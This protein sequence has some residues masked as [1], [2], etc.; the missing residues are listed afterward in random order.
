[1]SNK[2]SDM[3][4]SARIRENQRR[5]R[6]KRRELIEDLQQRVRDYELK[7]VE[8]T[9]DMQRAA[10]RVAQENLGLRSMLAQRGVTQEEVQSFLR[11]F[12]GNDAPVQTQRIALTKVATIQCVTPKA[13]S[14]PGA[15][16][17]HPLDSAQQ[18]DEPVSR[19]QCCPGNAREHNNA[20]QVIQEMEMDGLRLSKCGPT[21]GKYSSGRRDY[22]VNQVERGSRDLVPEPP[23]SEAPDCPNTADCFCPPTSNV[24]IPPPNKGLEISCDTATAIIIEM[25]G[26]GDID[27]VRASLGCKGREECTVRNST[28]LQIMDER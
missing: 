27:A 13:T 5:S 7:G 15:V 11:K 3:L 8:A 6:N 22:D 19:T 10:R 21:Q 2:G 25:R 16:A 24:D 9:Q 26:D 28:V 23:V 18:L 17:A 4:T 12:N 20:P 1:M 14:I